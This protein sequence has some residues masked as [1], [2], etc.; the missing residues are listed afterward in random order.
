MLATGEPFYGRELPVTL[1]RTP[2]APPEERLVDLVY[3]PLFDADGACTRILGHGT[4]VTEHV[5]ARRQ[6]EAAV[7]AERE[8]LRS[9]VLHMPA[10]VA[11]LAGDAG[12]LRYE[13]VNAAYTRVCAGRPLVGRTHRE[14]FPELA[15]QGFYELFERVYRTGESWAG[16]ETL[17]RYD[18]DGTGVVDTWLDLRLEPVR[19]PGVDGAPGPVVGLLNFAVDV[20]D[21]V[22]ARRQVEA[23]LAESE[24][25]RAEAEA[26]RARA[27]AERER[28]AQANQAK[29][30]FLAVMSHELRTPL[31]A[32]RRLR[33]AAGA[34]AARPGDGRPDRRARPRTGRAAAAPRPYQRRPQLR[35]AGGR[36][37]GVRT[38]RGGR[39]RGDRRGGP[40]DR[41]PALGQGPGARRAAARRPL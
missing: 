21:Q 22:R 24:R 19:E 7:A 37:R 15:G 34:G 12:G 2:G 6:A 11:L 10:P 29:A 17:A 39:A 25:A 40:V 31:N 23:L 14:A 32:I 28:A 1:A 35:Q 8:R 16:P 5:A 38:G 27:D 13:L 33:A 20:T 41:A 18:R 26:E 4:D 3:L 36:A 30:E 9:L